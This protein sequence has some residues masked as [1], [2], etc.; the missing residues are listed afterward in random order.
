M[1][2]LVRV[3]MDACR[4]K[5]DEVA[6]EIESEM[7]GIVGG[8]SRSGL[9]VGAIHIENTGEFSRFVGG[10]DGTGTG[11]TG[12]DHL[13]MLNDVN[14]NDR[15]YPKHARALYLKDYNIWRGSVRPYGGINFV[16]QIAAR[17]GG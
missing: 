17:H 5:V 7:K 3:L 4:D 13:A 12:T 15:I 1:G 6:Q 9:A 2:A 16:G 8:H 11:T 14:G 10:T